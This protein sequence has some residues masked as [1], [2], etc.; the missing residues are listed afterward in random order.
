MSKFFENLFF[1]WGLI[2]GIL[3]SAFYFPWWSY[4]LVGIILFVLLRKIHNFKSNLVISL[5][6]P[7]IYVVFSIRHFFK[8]DL[9]EASEK[10]EKIISSFE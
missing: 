9:E 5:L 8:S 6:W 10:L 3:M 1:G 7:I 4:C 2:T